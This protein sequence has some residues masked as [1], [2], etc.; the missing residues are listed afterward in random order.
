VFRRRDFDFQLHGLSEATHSLV[1][2]Q[3]ADFAGDG[4]TYPHEFES[5]PA[6]FMDAESVEKKLENR[7]I[8][9]PNYFSPKSQ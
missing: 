4:S 8:G 6:P 1:D 9:E 3:V 5:M 2:S 7:I